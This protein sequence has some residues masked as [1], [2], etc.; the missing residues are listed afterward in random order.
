M[1]R[2]EARRALLLK[3]WH[4]MT[5]EDGT[6]VCRMDR[7]FKISPHG[8]DNPDL[9]CY[10]LDRED[11]SFIATDGRNYFQEILSAVE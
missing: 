9:D 10:W 1:T 6:S 5:L 4:D 2:E 7:E 11:V 8:A 3:D